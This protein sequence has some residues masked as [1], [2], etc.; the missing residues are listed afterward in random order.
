M[1]GTE[2]GGWSGLWQGRTRVAALDPADRGLA[3]G[4]GLFETMRAHAGTLPWWPR[5]RARLAAGAAR[6]GIPLPDEALLD[7]ALGE[8]LARV[9]GGVVKLVLTR[10]AAARGYAPGPKAPPTLWV[11]ASPSLPPAASRPLV[12]DLLEVRLGVQPMLAGI[13]H[14][15]R[16]EQVLGAAEAARR[17]LD[18]GLMADAEGRLTAGTRGNLLLRTDGRWWTPALDHAG[19]AG[20]T[21]ALLLEAWT[22]PGG[23]RVDTLAIDRL[24]RIE[25]VLL[26]NA[27]RGILPAGRLGARALDPDPPGLDT[28]RAA[29]AAAHPAFREP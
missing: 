19:V 20:T 3:Y 8:A 21:R 26:V 22:P 1:A 27:L 14:L 11:T 18:E 2:P 24:D 13:K 5:H 29:L 9:P 16:L 17:G 15:N 10:G 7:A 25:A 23:L 12:I 28:A 4:D 6:L